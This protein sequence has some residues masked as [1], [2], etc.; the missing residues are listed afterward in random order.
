MLLKSE[1]MATGNN[2]YRLQ[3]D[4]KQ[5]APVSYGA[6]ALSFLHARCYLGSLPRG[7][8][9]F[10]WTHIIDPM[11]SRYTTEEAVKL[12]Q[13]LFAGSWVFLSRAPSTQAFVIPPARSSI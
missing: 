6:K 1:L 10:L 4:V 8:S 2:Y 9:L 7:S 3:T 11:S 5:L 13:G 12:T